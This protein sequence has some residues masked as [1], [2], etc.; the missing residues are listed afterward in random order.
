MRV[1]VDIN[2]LHEARQKELA[3]EHADEQ[4]KLKERQAERR[5]ALKEEHAD[6]KRRREEREKAESERLKQ[7]QEKEK[8]Y[9]EEQKA[10][11]ELAANALCFGC[12]NSWIK[13][14]LAPWEDTPRPDV[15][16]LATGHPV[17]VDTVF[18]CNLYS[19]MGEETPCFNVSNAVTTVKSGKT[20]LARSQQT[21]ST[22]TEE[23]H[24]E[25]C[26][27][28]DIQRNQVDGELNVA[29]SLKPLVKNIT[30]EPEIAPS[31]SGEEETLDGSNQE[32]AP[33]DA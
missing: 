29:D 13:V 20:Y 10:R 11:A 7:R 3:E 16:C 4:L 12:S 19:P 22:E 30:L 25:A 15:S 31:V 17:N 28:E 18:A 21:D 27:P 26:L 24:K 14:S 5:V 1:K 2:K 8:E 23:P 32:S 9:L 6:D 33:S